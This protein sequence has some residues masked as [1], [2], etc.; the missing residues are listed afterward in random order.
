[1]H[2]FRAQVHDDGIPSEVWDL[3]WDILGYYTYASKYIL[4]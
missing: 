3:V 1:M 4:S 2:Q